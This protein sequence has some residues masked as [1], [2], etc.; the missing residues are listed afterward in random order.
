M[1]SSTNWKLFCADKVAG[2][3][4]ARLNADNKMWIFFINVIYMF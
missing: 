1:L 3:A 4:A 2:A